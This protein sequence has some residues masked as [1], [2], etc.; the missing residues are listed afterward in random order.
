MQ[1]ATLYNLSNLSEKKKK[2]D[3]ALQFAINA[4]ALAKDLNQPDLIRGTAERLQE[5]YEK[6]R[7]LDSSLHYLKI[8]QE[9]D[10]II[11]VN[12]AKEVLQQQEMLAEFHQKEQEQKRLHENERIRLW[13]ISAVIFLIAVTMALLYF[14]VR[15]KA[16]KAEIENLELELLARKYHMEEKRLRAELETKSKELTSKAMIEIQRTQ[17][18]EEIIQKLTTTSDSNSRSIVNELKSLKMQDVWKEFETRFTQ[19]ESAFFDRLRE[20]SPDLTMNERR[21]CALLRMDMSTKE[22]ASL[23]HQSIR[24]V[25]LARI[26]LRKKLGLTNTDKSLTKFLAEL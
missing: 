24:G 19:V 26:G 12:E 14:M 22:I 13:A 23:T 2:G 20:I 25:E 21:L 15:N 11:K 18:I 4:Y 10:G 3:S 17:L 7:R 5:V 9:Y 16:R 1:A 6:N 8:V